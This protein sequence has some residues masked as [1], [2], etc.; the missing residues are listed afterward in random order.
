[1]SVKI[2]FD[3]TEDEDSFWRNY[4]KLEIEKDEIKEFFVSLIND[5]KI[6]VMD[7][8]DWIDEK[9]SLEELANYDCFE[10]HIYDRFYKRAL[11]EY[12]QPKDY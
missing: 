9:G 1:M 12:N 10:E 4:Y 8:L 5:N 2:L 6:T 3:V 11:M 7:L